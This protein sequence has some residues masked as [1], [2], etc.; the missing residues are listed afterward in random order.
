M[1][2]GVTDPT[3]ASPTLKFVKYNFPDRWQ[4]KLLQAQAFDQ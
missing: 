1:L 3:L 2:I 4:K